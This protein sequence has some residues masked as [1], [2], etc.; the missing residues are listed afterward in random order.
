VFVTAILLCNLTRNNCKII[1]HDL[2]KKATSIPTYAGQTK[3]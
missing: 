2:E 3:Y 1:T